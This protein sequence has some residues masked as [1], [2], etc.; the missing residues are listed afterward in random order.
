MITFIATGPI[1]FAS[2]RMR[3]YWPAQYLPQSRV[4]QLQEA[5]QIQCGKGDVIIWQKM[6]NT[7]L[8]SLF[9]E[10]GA[11]QIWDLCDPVY[12]WQPKESTQILGYMERVVLSSPG[13]KKDFDKWSGGAVASVMIPDRLELS[14]FPLRREHFTAFPIRFIWY[15]IMN[16]R[17]AIWG[18]VPN[19]ERLVASG[20][21]IELTVCDDRPDVEWQITQAFPMYNVRWSLEKENQ[22]LSNHDIA[23]LPPYPGPW[24]QVKSNNKKLTAYACGLPAVSGF[25]Y[26]ELVLLMNPGVRQATADE[27]FALVAEEYQA[28]LSAIEWGTVCASL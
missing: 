8:L 18:T 21:P 17:M 23:L 3:C 5:D 14:H 16:N 2:S 7:G 12:W 25:D 22:I 13:L 1:S 20:Y 10:R 9:H 26:D 19:L 11:K 27:G 6:V 15:G 24:G 4:V 28:Q